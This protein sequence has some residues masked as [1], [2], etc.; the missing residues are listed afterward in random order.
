MEFMKSLRQFVNLTGE[1]VGSGWGFLGLIVIIV[2]WF[3]VWVTLDFSLVW[4]RVF[5]VA[6]TS[7]TLLLVFALQASQNR[8]TAAIQ[9]K[10]DELIHASDTA[11][12]E[13]VSMET[14]NDEELE[15]LHE[16]FAQRHAEVQADG[17]A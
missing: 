13:L 11:A 8:A 6:A 9:R 4:Q 12:N 10:L 15:A 2:A 14:R 7:A 5:D 16:E 3:L 1:A 17:P